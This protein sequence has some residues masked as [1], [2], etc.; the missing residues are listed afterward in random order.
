MSRLLVAALCAIVI[1][2]GSTSGDEFQA[3]GT[4]KVRLAVAVGE[5]VYLGL[6]DLVP[7][8][9]PVTLDD[10][11]VSS[12]DGVTITEFVLDRLR[13]GGGGIGSLRQSEVDAETEPLV[14]ALSALNGTVIAQE[15]QFQLVI[16]AVADA[17]STMDFASVS[18]AFSVN[19]Q[20]LTQTFNAGA[21]VCFVTDYSA[22]AACPE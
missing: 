16:S 14:Q 21:K 9:A 10:L 4:T 20:R 2:C 13:T 6:V 15:D 3:G 11:A 22:T 7:N 5:P 1:A 19:G 8:R 18:L 12:P 17:P